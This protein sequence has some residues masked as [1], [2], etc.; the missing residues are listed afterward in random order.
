MPIL[1]AV[2]TGLL[3]GGLYALVGM[4]LALVFGV[5][6]IVNFAHGAFLMVGM[7]VAYFV[8]TWLHV[9]PYLGFPLVMA[10]LFGLGL[11]VYG[12]LVKQV[13]SAPHSMQ[14]LLTAGISLF[15]VGVAQIV[16]GAD[17]RQ[18]NL[19]LASH[20]DH[21]FGLTINRAYLVSFLLATAVSAGLYL[22]VARTD[23]GRAMRAVAQNRRIAAL[24]GI[25]VE[26][27]SALTFAIGA[28]CA[29]LGGALLLPVFYTYPTVGES[30]QIRSFVIVV[31]GGMGS[32][33]GAALGGVVLGIT[34]SLTAYLWSDS[35]S[36]VVNFVLFLV[37]LVVRPAGLLGKA[38]V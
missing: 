19:P 12:L 6:R 32:I 31:L 21:A 4:G 3:T 10:A 24:M 9:S 35:Y 5:M 34:E 13:M 27:V 23:L 33:E 20:N 28:A 8:C 1:Q 36:Q 38:S 2:L 26:R 25:R 16:F 22:L 7:Y 37:V 14:I 29:G 17:Y 11:A 15:F 30:F 18:L